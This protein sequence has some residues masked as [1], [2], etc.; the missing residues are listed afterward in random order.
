[1]V[2][3]RDFQEN[4]WDDEEDAS[5]SV[6]LT[7]KAKLIGLKDN[8][9][10]ERIDGKGL[11][12]RLRTKH[13]TLYSKPTWAL[14]ARRS[15]DLENSA[16]FHLQSLESSSNLTSDIIDLKRLPDIR[17]HPHSRSPIVATAFVPKLPIL[18][19]VNRV[20][21]IQFVSIDHK[22]NP[23]IRTVDMEKLAITKAKIS[24]DGEYL[25]AIGKTRFIYVYH[26]LN[27]R[28]DKVNCIPDRSEKEWSEIVFSPS[29][30]FLAALGT[31]GFIAIISLK[32]K[33]PLGQLKMNCEAKAACISSDGKFLV[34]AGTDHFIYI[35][36]TE[37]LKCVRKTA[38]SDGT[39]VTTLC[40]SPQDLYLTV[41]NTMGI[42]TIY[43]F[44]D[45]LCQDQHVVPL[46]SLMNLT[47]AITSLQWHPSSEML[48]FASDAANNGLRLV[49]FPSL[50]VFSNFPDS[51]MPL[52]QVKSVE[53]GADGDLLAVGCGDGKV[54]M[55]AI[56]HFMK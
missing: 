52:G 26:L 28:V 27:D 9:A 55:F 32:T 18:M 21:S 42:V 14:S 33:R 41:G 46:K 16:P 56:K 47:T 20:P 2:D 45:L 54:R 44:Q 49:H 13:E 40:L 19:L 15:E 1:M 11:L 53:F 5:I 51:R 50:R 22:E 3:K 4:V 25:V 8:A 37:N 31:D 34:T 12:K 30:S 29:N 7:K 38:Y 35:W 10:E 17:I 48:A 6:N 36:D 43:K 24:P 39:T 23:T